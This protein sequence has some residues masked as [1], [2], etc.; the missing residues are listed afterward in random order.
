MDSSKHSALPLA[1]ASVIDFSHLMPGPW[2]TQTLG[3]LG[4]DVIKVEQ[5]GVGDPSR[6][7]PPAY[8]EGSVYFHSV[9]RNK[10]SITLDLRDAA[11]RTVLERL[12]GDADIVVESYRPGVAA[13]LGI[14]YASAAALNPRLIYCSLNGYGSEGALAATP[15]HDAAVQSIAGLMHVAP[16]GVAPMPRIQTGDWSAA[17]YATIGILAA[18]VRQQASG[19][20]AHIETSM[21]DALMSWS[22][23]ALSSA[24]ARKAGFSGEPPLQAFGANPRY[25]T[26]PTADGKAVTV[27]LLEARAWA[28][29]CEHIGRPDL[30]Y[31]ETPADRH[32]IHPGRTEGFRAAIADF[33][34]ARQRDALAAE[35]SAAGIAITP[36]YTP[37][38]AL[39]SP[40]AEARGVVQFIDHPHEGRIPFIVDPLYR[41]GLSDPKRR[42]APRIGEHDAEIRSELGIVREPATPGR[43]A[44]D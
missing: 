35:A 9:N 33:C 13:K 19:E 1:G 23:I 3:D 43:Q 31:D 24:L 15:G 10:R 4:A 34:S 30:A 14:D 11:D 37:E 29:F 32:T 16:D 6:F 27:C 21:Y 18:Y 40:V 44:H 26:F 25:S 41:S 38:E 7:N 12:L 5:K 36:V 2:C 17:A 8:R 39:S 42:P 28:R 20:G 22:S